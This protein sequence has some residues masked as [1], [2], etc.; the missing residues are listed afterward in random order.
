M[1]SQLFTYED[2]KQ[3]NNFQIIRYE[4]AVFRGQMIEEEKREGVG[5]MIYDSGR[6]Y[7]GGWHL[8]RRS[9]P[10]YEKYSN[11]NIYEGEFF[12]GKAHGYGVYSWKNGEIY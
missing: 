6:I 5:I 2:L 1:V 4:D 7:E 3:Q 10:G 11:G 8:D 9:G 12:Q